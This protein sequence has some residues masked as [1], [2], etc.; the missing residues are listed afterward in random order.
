MTYSQD[1]IEVVEASVLNPHQESSLLN[2]APL[3]VVP[4]IMRVRESLPELAVASEDW[5]RKYLKPDE[6]DERLRLSFW[7][8]Y[9]IV[10]AGTYKRRMR[11]ESILSG[12][13]NNNT[14]EKVYACNDK[15][16][17][18]VLTPPKSYVQSMNYILHL[19]TERLSEIMSLP[20]KDEDGNVDHKA[21]SL[22]LK[23]FEMVDMRVKG[24][25]IQKMQV[26]QKNLNVHVSAPSDLEAIR[27][28]DDISKLEALS[29]KL[30]IEAPRNSD[31]VIGTLTPSAD[32]VLL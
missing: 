12:I 2:V 31:E 24:G 4:L 6:R 32:D 16:L 11:L 10:T 19:G 15:K 17:L 3:K 21:A 26:E 18:W 28:I 7:D 29:N 13:C 27:G 25:I 22:I 20:I 8:E 9:N 1:A 14:W 30:E 23:A 5:L